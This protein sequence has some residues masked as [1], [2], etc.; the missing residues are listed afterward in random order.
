MTVDRMQERYPV[1]SLSLGVLITSV[2]LLFVTGLLFQ[3]NATYR[4][5]ILNSVRLDRLKGEILR[6]DELLTMS[7]RMGAATGDQRWEERYLREE[8]NLDRA[9][10]EVLTLLPEN[11]DKEGARITDE[12]NAKLIDM[13]KRAFETVRL[14]KAQEAH[15]LLMSREYES[16]KAIYAQGM[17]ALSIRMDQHVEESLA[18]LQDKSLV[19]IYVALGLIPFVILFWIYTL[20]LLSRWKAFVLNIN[21]SLD[22]EV[23]HRTEQLQTEKVRSLSSAKMATLG[24]MA[25]GIAHEINNPL[26]IIQGYSE[27][28]R[29]LCLEEHLRR[30]Q[31]EN[32]SEKIRSGT[33]RISKII[34]GLRRFSRDGSRDPFEMSSLK[35]II[36]QTLILCKE[37]IQFHGIDLKVDVT[38]AEISVPCRPVEI[39]QVLLNLLHNAVDALEQSELKLISIEVRAEDDTIS[40]EVRDSGP[41]IPE[42]L[43]TKIMQPFFSTKPVGKGTGL[44]L[45]IAKTIMSGHRGRLDLH[46]SPLG[47]CFTMVLP[48]TTAQQQ[49]A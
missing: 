16:Q 37:K 1:F 35:S 6:L 45:S 33:E 38:Q 13:E 28:L 17:S 5:V 24:E 26:G 4:E 18:E 31:L 11:D 8:A 14:G 25:S 21:K 9:I 40:I 2:S 44:G 39:S 49:I 7:A 32:V 46:T 12:A 29:I 30:D 48:R 27:Y 41:G 10:K 20:G 22:E 19:A 23:L 36:E 47:T 42:N 3:L 15:A 34:N 43:Q